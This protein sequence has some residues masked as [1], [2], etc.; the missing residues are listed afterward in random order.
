MCTVASE[1]CSERAVDRPTPEGVRALQ[2]AGPVGAH[3]C[4]SNVILD[5]VF[6]L[7]W[8]VVGALIF[9]RRS[10]ERMALLVSTFLVTFGPSRSIPRMPTHLVSSHPAWLLPVRGVG[11]VGMFVSVL[12]F[13]LFPGGRFVPRWTRWLAVA[14]IAQDVSPRTLSRSVL[15]V[16]CPGEDFILVFLGRYSEP[17]LVPGLSLPES[18]LS[19]ATSPDQVGHLRHGPGCRGNLPLPV[20]VDLPG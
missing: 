6:Q 20:P 18:L 5:K 13:L 3:L 14:F 10:D 9:W 19:G 15:S 2:D 4:V 1:V 7:V 8:F 16:A 17:G 11:L 12:F